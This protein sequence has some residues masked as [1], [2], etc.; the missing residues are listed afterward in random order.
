MPVAPAIS[1]RCLRALIWLAAVTFANHALAAPPT[2][3]AQIYQTKCAVCHGDN[4]QGTDDEYPES[5]TGD[6]S[7]TELA[8]LIGKTMPKEEVGTCVGEDADKV[9]A[10]IHE[11]FYSPAAQERN[12]PPRIE[13]AH[14]TVRQYRHSV[15]DLVGS[16]RNS[17]Q[18]T[19]ER[20]LRAEYF[21]TSKLRGGDRV[22]E[23]IDPAVN[24]TFE[25]STPL[26][27]KVE[28]KEYSMRWQGSILAPETGEYEFIVKT[29]NGA[30]LWINDNNKPLIDA[31]VKSGD[32]LE[33]RETLW[34]LGGRAYSVRLE[35]FKSK[36]KQGSIAL[37]WRL[38]RRTAT[39]IP[40][41]YLLTQR[42]PEL[43]ISSTPFP[44]DDRSVGYER[45]S[46]VS[47]AWDV[48]TTDAAIE[49]A[50]KIARQLNELAGTRP[51]A[52]DRDGK[53]REFCRRFAARAFRRPLSEEQQR[54]FIDRQFEQAKDADSA[55]KRVLLLVLKSPR[56]LYPEAQPGERDDYVVAARLALG[57][58]DSL[59]D[60]PLLDAAAKGQLK[61][62]EQVVAHADRLAK[63]P[64]ARAK[65]RDF[66]LLWLRVDHVTDLAKD[67]EKFPE[68]TSELAADL[69]ASLDLS[70]DD[71]VESDEADF[72][73][74]LLADTVYLN[75]RLARFYGATIP[76]DAP[77]QKVAWEPEVRAGLLTHPFLL[78]SFAYTATSS[79]IHRGV[80]VARSIL[81]RTLRPP[82]EAVTPL[83]PDLHAD[84][85]TRERVA[86]QT[87]GENCQGCHALINPLGFTLE[88]FDAVGR[89]RSQEQGRP[90][91]ASGVYQS[92][93]G[94]LRELRGVRELAS[95]LVASNET[96][97][98]VTQQL[99]QY[100][101]K[102]PIRAYGPEA[103]PELQ[104]SLAA[105]DFNLRRL[106]VDIM[107]LAALRE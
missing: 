29:H 76:D 26:P 52:N 95:Y 28:P 78:T 20:G 6:R 44:P 67:S 57:M 62:R 30:R 89:Y 47:K 55:V 63:D 38:P 65:L 82:P 60:Q 3:G 7:I 105:N 90:I 84:L 92:R 88:N 21:K 23:R 4:G 107:V 68:F 1:A 83:T 77:F 53:L 34:L 94:E 66:L 12:R 9:A 11:T 25:E 72:R 49:V 69:R 37:L 46:A 43:L 61:T 16:F 15:A 70:V 24:F 98:A 10:Y 51:D 22:L 41:Q 104:R 18:L 19:T 64:R 56:F 73:Q 36:E 86:L 54:L 75:G 8:T 17:G 45:G 13:L 39:I 99:F 27:G 50:G 96:Q 100:L 58:W 14:L 33:Y 103:L 80:F 48:A 91:D 40:A 102:Q 85:T 101:V 2:T 74:L 31:S 5:L 32:D 42:A 106:M 93:T 35:Y 59:P 71:L 81:G 79:P 97:A 87:K